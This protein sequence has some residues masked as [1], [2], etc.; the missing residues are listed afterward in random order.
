MHLFFLSLKK[1]GKQLQPGIQTGGWVQF[2]FMYSHLWQKSMHLTGISPG[3]HCGGGGPERKKYKIRYK[4]VNIVKL[5]KNVLP[6]STGE[7]R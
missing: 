2:P 7:K 3:G 6:A 4:L 1:P 5:Y